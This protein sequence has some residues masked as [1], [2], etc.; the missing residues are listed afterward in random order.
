M[1][2]DEAKKHWD[3]SCQLLPSLTHKKSRI[4]VISELRKRGG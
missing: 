1:E 3:F 4:L 2:L